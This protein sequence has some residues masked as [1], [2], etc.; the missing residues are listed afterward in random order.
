MPARPEGRVLGRPWRVVL[1]GHA[2]LRSTDRQAGQTRSVVTARPP[3]RAANAVSC[4]PGSTPARFATSSSANN[5]S[6]GRGDNSRRLPRRCLMST[7][8]VSAALQTFS[9]GE[10]HGVESSGPYSGP[11]RRQSFPSPAWHGQ[12]LSDIVRGTV[13]PGHRRRRRPH[14]VVVQHLS[15]PLVSGE[16]GILERLVEAG[17][18]PTVHLLVRPLAAVYARL[19]SRPRSPPSTSSV[20]PI[21][22]QALGLRRVVSMAEGMADCLV[23]QHPGVPRAGQLEQALDATNRLVHCLHGSRMACHRRWCL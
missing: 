11:R 13:V 22:S 7:C 16:A 5:A 6:T 4:W 21:G 14:E 20:R 18:R 17:A 2:R 9:L 8:P 10:D 3:K 1:Q 19:R 23:R 12:T 15:E